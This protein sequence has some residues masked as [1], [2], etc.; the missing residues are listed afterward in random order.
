MYA[1]GES[2]PATKGF[3]EL[4]RSD[5]HLDIEDK[6]SDA[7][8]AFSLLKDSWQKQTNDMDKKT[9]FIYHC[10]SIEEVKNKTK[11][12]PQNYKDYAIRRYFN[13]IISQTSED[14]FCSYNICEKESNKFHRYIDFRILGVPFDLKVS[15]YPARFKHSRADFRSEREYRNALIRWL[16]KNQSGEQ[17]QH[18]KNRLFILCKKGDGKTPKANNQLKTRLDLIDRQVQSFL[19]F[20]LSKY[21]KGEKVFNDL[22]ID[23]HHIFSDVILIEG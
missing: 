11:K 4:K 5:I 17:R 20:T 18:Y 7:Q 19:D 16:Y 1:P 21:Y 6:T 22:M 8:K 9:R 12:L 15:S 3:G 13:K 10:H 23:G 14:I 2:R